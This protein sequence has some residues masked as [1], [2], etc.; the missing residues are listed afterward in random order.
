MAS[1]SEP[2]THIAGAAIRAYQLN[3]SNN[4]NNRTIN[5]FNRFKEQ[6]ERAAFG[7]HRFV[8]IDEPWTNI[9]DNKFPMLD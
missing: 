5:A 3:R 9:R 1:E 2:A 4:L 8:C 7:G 6:S